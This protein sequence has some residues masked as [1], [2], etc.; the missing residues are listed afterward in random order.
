MRTKR[1]IVCV[2]G[3]S[4]YVLLTGAYAV[5]QSRKGECLD[6]G[7]NR[8]MEEEEKKQRRLARLME[9]ESEGS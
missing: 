3:A 5:T 4:S 7:T 2:C 8:R 9:D 6:C 1:K